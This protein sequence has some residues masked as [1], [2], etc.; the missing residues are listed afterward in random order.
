[1]EMKT[2]PPI[3]TNPLESPVKPLTATYC[4]HLINCPL[5]RE[6]LVMTRFRSKRDRSPTLQI[7][8]HRSKFLLS[9][10]LRDRCRVRRRT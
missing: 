4:P 7:F 9:S 2:F 10:Y 6:G 8:L 1:M 5:I 3:D